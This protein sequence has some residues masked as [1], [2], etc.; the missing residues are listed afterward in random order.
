MQKIQLVP[1]E[2]IHDYT[3]E[4]VTDVPLPRIQEEIVDVIQCIS[5]ECISER[6]VKPS[7]LPYFRFTT[8][9]SERRTSSLKNVC[10]S[11]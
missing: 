3:M 9:L 11:A 7:T 4:E 8:K 5:Q 1:Q 2:Q 6:I 10:N